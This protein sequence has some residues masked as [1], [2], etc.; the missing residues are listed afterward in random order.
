MAL[1][2]NP[3]DAYALLFRSRS[4]AELRQFN[5]ALRDADDLVAIP[6][7]EINRQGYLD[8]EGDRLDFHIVALENRA[9]VYDAFGQP[10]RAE[11]DLTAAV[12]YSRSALALS[13]R[14]KFL[15]YKNGQE[16]QA[17]SDLDEA[18]SLGSVDSRVFY[19]KGR[20]HMEFSR[21][22]RTRWLLSM[23]R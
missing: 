22:R 6:P 17:L 16:K 21:R 1:A 8:G 4:H 14:G 3:K 5:E 15:A 9:N 19:A 11:Q 10:G 13:A 2:A 20:L 18:I 23:V 12:T 7:A